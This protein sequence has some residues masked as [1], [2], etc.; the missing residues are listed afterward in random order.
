MSM[1]DFTDDKLGW[2]GIGKSWVDT[3]I[4]RWSEDWRVA[5][6]CRVF[7]VVYDQGKVSVVATASRGWNR[8]SVAGQ[9]F[10]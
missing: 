5:W 1:A 3:G 7:V 9:V 2:V 4:V 10:E 8:S 6:E